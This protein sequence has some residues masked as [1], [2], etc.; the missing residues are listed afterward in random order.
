M[1][2]HGLWQYDAFS[3]FGKVPGRAMCGSGGRGEDRDAGGKVDNEKQN[4]RALV[5][6]SIES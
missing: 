2:V 3:C 1:S 4:T 6:C 5:F